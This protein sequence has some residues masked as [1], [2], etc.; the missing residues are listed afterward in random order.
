MDV[1]LIQKI[2]INNIVKNTKRT[3]EKLF[4]LHKSGKMSEEDFM[5]KLDKLKDLVIRNTETLKDLEREVVERSNVDPTKFLVVEHFNHLG[6][7]STADYLALKLGVPHD[8]D[9]YKMILGIK[10]ELENKNFIPA[11]EFCKDY[12]LLFRNNSFETKLKIYRFVNLCR[13]G[14][15]QKALAYLMAELKKNTEAVRKFLPLLIDSKILDVEDSTLV[16]DFYGAMLEVFR[17]GKT[18]RLS[19]RVEYGMMAFKTQECFKERNTKCPTCC[20]ELVLREEIPYNR[21]EQSI[22]LCRGSGTELDDVNQPHAYDNGH[23]Y[24]NEYIKKKNNLVVCPKTGKSSS[25][26]PR[27]CYFV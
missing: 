17:L 18:T 12:R 3:I 11:L 9:F 14:N 5:L 7:F 27:L 25:K 23:V 16:E 2:K 4:S 6:E 13:D 15:S 8:Q 1:T 21:H 24:G 20:P 22:I 19:D 10:R 26:Y